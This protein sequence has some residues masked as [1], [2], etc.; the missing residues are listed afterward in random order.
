MVLHRPPMTQRTS[1]SAFVHPYQEPLANASD[2][3]GNTTEQKANE[4]LATDRLPDFH[5][6]CGRALGFDRFV[7]LGADKSSTCC[8]SVLTT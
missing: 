7:V 6:C 8:I 1:L 5:Y 3:L 4:R 2:S